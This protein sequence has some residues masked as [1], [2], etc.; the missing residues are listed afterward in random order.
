MKKALL[1]TVV[2]ATSHVQAQSALET[3]FAE[4]SNNLHT[5]FVNFIRALPRSDDVHHAHSGP[6]LHYTDEE[7]ETMLRDINARTLGLRRKLG[8]PPLLN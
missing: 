8:L 5:A 2:V 6:Q 4:W 3:S 1:T 7:S